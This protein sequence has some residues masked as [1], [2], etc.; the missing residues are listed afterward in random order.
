VLTVT[1]KWLVIQNAD[2]QQFPIS[3]DSIGLFIVRSPIS[4]GQIPEN[5]LVEATG[6]DS[7]EAALR[8]N[9]IDVYVGGAR[10]LVTPTFLYLTARGQMLRQIDFTYNPGVYGDIFGVEAPIQG[11]VLAGA[12]QIHVVGPPITRVP[13]RLNTPGSHG[14]GVLPT[15]PAGL[16]ATQ[17]TPGSASSLK[18]GDPVY[19]VATGLG[20]KTVNLSHLIV[21]K[22]AP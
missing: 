18:P 12:I 5:S 6:V 8:T 19:Y 4:V 20:S 7:G 16:N 10:S 3:F 13:L 17:I 14:I 2:G 11:N 21:Y 9:H 15:T 22:Q 1:N